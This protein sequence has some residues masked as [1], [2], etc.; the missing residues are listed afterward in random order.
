[1]NGDADHAEVGVEWVKKK[2]APEQIGE[3]QN[4]ASRWQR[5]HEATDDTM[6]AKL[7]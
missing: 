2:L 6:A 3:A 7:K 4:R 5:S 1:M